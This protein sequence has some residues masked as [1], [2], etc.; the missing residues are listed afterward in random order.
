MCIKIYQSV[1][2]FPSEDAARASFKSIHDGEA[3]DLG[4]AV[5]APPLGQESLAMVREKSGANEI[6]VVFRQKRI[7][8]RMTMSGADMEQFQPYLK[9]AEARVKLWSP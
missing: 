5:G 7:L 8:V 9:R 2:V 1:V 4:Q 3:T 6:T